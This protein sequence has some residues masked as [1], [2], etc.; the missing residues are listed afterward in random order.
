MIAVIELKQGERL[1]RHERYALVKVGSKPPKEGAAIEVRDEGQTFFASDTPNDVMV[2]IERAK[3][4]ASENAL[5]CVYVK[6]DRQ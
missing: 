1:Q 2:I 6:R 5:T 4:W 3:V